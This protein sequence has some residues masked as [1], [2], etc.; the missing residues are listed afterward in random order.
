MDPASLWNTSKQHAV[1]GARLIKL[2]RLWLNIH[3]WIGLGFAVLL[4]P[5]SLSG[6][7][8]VWHDHLD[9][10]VNPDRYA[11]T[12]GQVQPPSAL[13]ASASAALGRGFEPVVVRMPE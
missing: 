9:A 13:L 1:P 5:I 2:R 8:L 11:V 3:L 10:I 7:L 12:Q 4:I 6:A